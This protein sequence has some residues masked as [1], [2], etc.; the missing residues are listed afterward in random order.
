[1]NNSEARLNQSF[2]I[3][4]CISR[5]N[6]YKDAPSRLVH[7]FRAVLIVG[8]FF[9]PAKKRLL[10]G[11]NSFSLE[12][13]K[14][15]SVYTVAQARSV[16]ITKAIVA[17]E[18]FERDAEDAFTTASSSQKVSSPLASSPT[19]FVVPTVHAV[20]TL[21]LTYSLTAHLVLSQAVFDPLA[22]SPTAFDS[23]KLANGAKRPTP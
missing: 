13:N 14:R 15:G 3:G 10:A 21:D 19:V 9:V 22:S 23:E 1:L 16:A 17:N 8:E 6:R 7:P 11:R 20:H 5:D 12:R 4:F 18:M 2:P